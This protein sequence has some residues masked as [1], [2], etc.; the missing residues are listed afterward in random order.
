MHPGIG[1]HPHTVGRCQ[2]ERDTST[3][4][5]RVSAGVSVLQLSAWQSLELARTFL[6]YWLLYS[7]FKSPFFH[8]EAFPV[9][10]NI[11]LECRDNTECNSKNH[12]NHLS[13][14]KWLKIKCF[15][16]IWVNLIHTRAGFNESLSPVNLCCVNATTSVAHACLF[17]T[18]IP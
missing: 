18:W 17:H 5:Q 8:L 6:P 4:P 16:C 1:C 12:I 11:S 9:N 3:E 14:V 2:L 7:P 13:R 10:A 15:N